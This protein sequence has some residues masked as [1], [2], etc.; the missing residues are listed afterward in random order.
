MSHIRWTA[1]PIARGDAI[2]DWSLQVMS[3]FDQNK[4]QICGTRKHVGPNYVDPDLWNELMEVHEKY[5]DL[6]TWEMKS[7]S[8][9]KADVMLGVVAMAA[10]VEKAFSWKTCNN[11]H[12]PKGKKKHFAPPTTQLLDDPATMSKFGL[13][14]IP[15]TSISLQLQHSVLD[16]SLQ[17]G[18]SSLENVI[19]FDQQLMD[20]AKGLY[21]ESREDDV[22]VASILDSTMRQAPQPAENASN[23]ANAKETWTP[24]SILRS[25]IRKLSQDDQGS[26]ANTADRTQRKSQSAMRKWSRGLSSNAGVS[27]FV[28][29]KNLLKRKGTR[30]PQKKLTRVEKDEDAEGV[31]E[32]GMKSSRVH[33]GEDVE[34]D[35]EDGTGGD[36]KVEDP[37][38]AQSIVQQVS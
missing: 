35:L 12:H 27:A 15:L 30:S 17:R 3:K 34:D 5:G 20:R 14:D 37:L 7:L 16:E 24:R 6:A 36:E 10:G 26:S 13:N 28:V 11:P 32:E 4:R 33:E 8:V 21:L 31:L 18:G 22:M 23:S 1:S 29:P 2:C 9:G 19:A 25:V 38:T